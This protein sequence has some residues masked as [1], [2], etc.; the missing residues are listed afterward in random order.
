MYVLDPD[1]QMHMQARIHIQ[2]KS[3]GP[4]VNADSMTRPNNS[5]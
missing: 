1:L 2:Q 3:L 4:V 5:Y